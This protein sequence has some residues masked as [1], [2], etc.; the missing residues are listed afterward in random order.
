MTFSSFFCALDCINFFSSFAVYQGNSC[1][2][3]PFLGT[4]ASPYFLI[5]FDRHLNQNFFWPKIFLDPKVSLTRNFLDP[6]L[7]FDPNGPN[8]Y[9]D[10]KFFFYP[11]YVFNPNI[12]GPQI[13]LTQ[14]Y[15]DPKFFW[16]SFF[17]LNQSQLKPFWT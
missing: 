16:P 6:K 9:F 13:F 14:N 10:S 12:F 5:D 15:F 11:K 4:W 8:I 3:L 17:P 2:F 7:F 1:I